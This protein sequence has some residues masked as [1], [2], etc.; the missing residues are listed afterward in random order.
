[1]LGTDSISVSTASADVIT[2]KS[3]SF[4]TGVISQMTTDILYAG[5][6][7]FTNR[8]RATTGIL[9]AI[10]T[11]SYTILSDVVTEVTKQVTLF[12]TTAITFTKVC[13]FNLGI[14]IGQL[15]IT[16]YPDKAVFTGNSVF[17]SLGLENSIMHFS[18]YLDNSN[19]IYYEP[20]SLAMFYLSN[21][22]IFSSI[23]KTISS[24]PT[25]PTQLVIKGYVD[26]EVGKIR[27]LSNNFLSVQ[28]FTQL[29]ICNGNTT[30]TMDTQL[31]TKSYVDSSIQPVRIYVDTEI[32]KIKNNDI[33]FLGADTFNALTQFRIA[34]RIQTIQSAPAANDFITRQVLDR[35]MFETFGYDLV[36]LYLVRHYH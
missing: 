13:T 8:P 1:M 7:F 30:P 29:P 16:P 23:P 15:L 12:T 22:H 33:I 2:A 5:Q 6:S 25:L 18:N 36:V 27:S 35:K 24:M 34:P 3:A 9:P 31:I 28:F 26:Q 21:N 17:T 14:N 11:D 19:K 20:N 10:L 32:N 4:Q